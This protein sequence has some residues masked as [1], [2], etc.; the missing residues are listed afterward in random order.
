MHNVSI[1]I[2]FDF[3][4]EYVSLLESAGKFEYTIVD[5]G[6][7]D[8]NSVRE[9]LEKAQETKIF[10]CRE[11]LGF[12]K[13]YDGE[14]LVGLSMPRVIDPREYTVWKLEGGKV[15]HRMGMIYLKE[16]ARGKGIGKIAAKLFQEQYPNLL[17]VIDPRNIPSKR[18]AA[19][20]GLTMNGMLYTLGSRWKHTPWIHDA[21][22]EIWS[23]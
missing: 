21:K 23:N 19:S 14:E 16:E 4:D 11:R 6:K 3:D 15:Y 7:H 12:L 17:W 9:L 1:K 8:L 10:N 18:V 13:I 2:D 22:L 5:E 20:V